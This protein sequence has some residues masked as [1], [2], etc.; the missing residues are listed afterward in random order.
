ML[1]FTTRYSRFLW[2]R[3]IR[4]IPAEE[5]EKLVQLTSPEELWW[6]RLIYR[7]KTKGG[8][9]VIVHLVRIPPTKHWDIEWVHEPEP[10]RGVKI[11]VDLAAGK[12]RNAQSVRPYHF[13]EEQQPVHTPL[14][15]IMSAG[16]ASVEVPPFRYHT[17]V[18]FRVVGGANGR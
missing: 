17:M 5:A 18:V 1:Q 6:K 11:T 4:A 13:E 15:A 3:D 10:L 16:R 8:F 14:E 2:A 7:R 9:E 12:L